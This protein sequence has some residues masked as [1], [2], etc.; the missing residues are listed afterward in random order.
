MGLGK[1]KS[2]SWKLL[3]W[4]YSVLEKNS[5]NIVYMYHIFW[6][7][8]HTELINE[9]ACCFKLLIANYLAVKGEAYTP[10][11]SKFKTTC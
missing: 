2:F 10:I 11:S 9:D 4:I 1:K 3:K 6:G 8:R 7:E 5:S